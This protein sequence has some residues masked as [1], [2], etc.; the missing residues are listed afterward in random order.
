MDVSYLL[1]VP[2]P[3]N[4]SRQHGSGWSKFI[5]PARIWLSKYLIWSI[6]SGV[7]QSPLAFAAGSPVFNSIPGSLKPDYFAQGFE[8][9][10][11]SEIS[12][13]LI[14][15]GTNRHLT[16]VTVT[17]SSWARSE[18]YGNLASYSHPLTLK[19]Y[20]GGYFAAPG[21]LLANVTQTFDIPYRT[22]GWVSNGIAFN[23]TFDCSTLGLSLPN[24]IIYTV[25]AN[26]SH[27]GSA[28]TG[29]DSSQACNY[30]GFAYAS[31]TSNCGGVTVGANDP[32]DIFDR[33]D[34]AAY[35]WDG[36][37]PAA[38]LRRDAASLLKSVPYTP[39][40]AVYADSS[41]LASSTVVVTGPSSFTYS[42]RSQGPASSTVTGSSG[43]VY[44]LYRG[45]GA[46]TYAP[47]A[48]PPTSAGTY[49]VVASV[50]SDSRYS[51]ASSSGFTFDISPAPIVVSALPVTKPYGSSLVLGSGQSAFST[52]GLVNGETSET[53]TLTASGGTG[54]NDAVGTYTLTPSALAGGTFLKANYSITYQASTLSV[55]S[56]STVSGRQLSTIQ[57]TGATGFTYSGFYQGPSTSR[58]TG[59]TGAVTYLYSGSGSTTY[60]PS[61]I[62][63]VIPGTYSVTASVAVDSTYSS[64]VSAPLSFTI[65][66]APLII[67]ASPKS[68]TYG[69]ALTLGSGQTGFSAAGL[70]NGDTAGTV[71]I[72]ASGGT[73]ITDFAGSYV[74]T[75]SQATGGTFKPANYAIAYLPGTLTVNKVASTIAVVG[76]NV[77][78]YS[79]LG[80]GPTNVAVVG[81]AGAVSLS[82]ASVDGTSYAANA[83][84]PTNTGSYTVTASVAS[85]TNHLAA[86]SA[87]FAFTIQPELLTITAVDQTKIY[88]T[89]PSL[90]AGQTG[91][92]ATGLVNGE[93]VGSVTLSASGGT[94]AGDGVG[95][96]V[97]TPSGASGGTFNAANYTIQYVNGTLTVSPAVLMISVVLGEG[98]STVS[99]AGDPTYTY[100]GTP[101]GPKA[102]SVTG[103]SG[104]VSFVYSGAGT[105]PYVAS[106]VPPIEPGSYQV[107]ATVASDLNFLGATSSP[108]NFKII[109][110]APIASDVPLLPPWGMATLFVS[111]IGVAFRQLRGHRR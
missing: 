27:Y 46:T 81:S 16:A 65:S 107:V 35:Y 64:A 63:P 85:D 95:S 5:L 101:R 31:Q 50:T 43:A 44:Y 14:L 108:V 105:T 76:T 40:V 97:L 93:S 62:P 49:S 79:G 4:I 71:T 36:A 29:G 82:Y 38:W 104:Q 73:G 59:S 3:P 61:L 98:V 109:S 8:S 74:L 17:L 47:S 86:T 75:P 7:L 33:R 70:L 30:L 42:G 45:I 67:T 102:A 78:T 57:V 41:T 52:S 92:T 20:Q 88:G 51:S 106:S 13:R 37:A 80:Q 91:F 28:P 90:G 48:T 11:I 55:I 89:V 15:A 1:P 94:G 72:S 87:P 77:F 39:M 84:A 96:Y 23:V 69:T 9:Q 12:D 66:P 19:I 34:S 68:K 100:T 110:E 10:R 25:S 26:T 83:S 111:V 60:G 24:S 2:R 58:V 99:V 6:L 54:V 32:G 22:V 56:S 18:N 21:Q 103:S 53:A